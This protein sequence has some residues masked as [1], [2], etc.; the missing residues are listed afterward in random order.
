MFDTQIK[1]I[2][3]KMELQFYSNANDQV[4]CHARPQISYQNG[5]V[6][7][8]FGSSSRNTEDELNHK[9]RTMKKKRDVAWEILEVAKHTLEK[10]FEEIG[11]HLPEIVDTCYKDLI[12]GG[13]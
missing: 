6:M 12:F 1:Y 8:L 2:M 5:Y 9:L 11:Q 10:K 13:K 3:S 4:V 7:D